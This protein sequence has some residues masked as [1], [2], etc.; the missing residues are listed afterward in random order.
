[1]HETTQHPDSIGFANIVPIVRQK[2]LPEN[3]TG[4]WSAAFL[5]R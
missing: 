2:L 5:L 4:I 3:A 1:M